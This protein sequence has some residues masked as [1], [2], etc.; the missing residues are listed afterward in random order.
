M[1]RSE[2][3]FLLLREMA[4]VSDLA[5]RRLRQ[6]LPEGLGEAQFDL[7]N[8]LV[9]TDNRDET[10]S[11]L[12]RLFGISRPAMTQT[13]GRMRSAGLVELVAAPADGRLR[14]VRLTEI[15]RDRHRAVL[16]SLEEDASRLGARLAREEL[17][18]LLGQTRRFRLEAERALAPL[19][20]ATHP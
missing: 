8:H 17:E 6:A 4:I 9:F 19:E 3:T 10:P 11:D 18:T 14:H 13:L 12:A 2:S 7:L 15:G 5:R 1:T 20:E 16:A